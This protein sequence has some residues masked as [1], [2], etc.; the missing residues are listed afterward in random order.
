MNYLKDFK[1]F[2]RTETISSSVHILLLLCN[3]AYCIF[4][5]GLHILNYILAFAFEFS[6]IIG[7]GCFFLETQKVLK[8]ADGVDNSLSTKDKKNILSA[9]TDSITFTINIIGIFIMTVLSW[10]SAVAIML[11]IR[12]VIVTIILIA[13]IFF[14][15]YMCSFVFEWVGKSL[16]LMKNIR[17]SIKDDDNNGE[18]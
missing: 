5:E 8:I 15:A 16:I 2:S 4:V 3:A 1:R 18:K 9:T 17:K 7:I 6:T 11:L 14:F 10:V 12:N 13:K